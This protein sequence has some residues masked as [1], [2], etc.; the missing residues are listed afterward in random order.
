MSR[1]FPIVQIASIASDESGSIAIGPFGSAMK[2]DLYVSEGVPVIR[3]NNVGAGRKVEGDF[4]YVS[5]ETALRLKRSRLKT[6]D[7]FF[8]HRGAIGTVGIIDDSWPIAPLM[9]SS[10]MRLR[11]NM[12]IA[13]PE[14]VFWFFKSAEGRHEILTYASTVGTPGIGTPLTSLKSM[15]LPLPPLPEQRE[16]AAILG[17]LDDKIELN[18]KTS[19]TL[20]AMARALY[21]SWFV[22]FDPVHARVEGRRPAHMP[23]QTA[24]LFPDSFGEDGLPEGW[25]WAKI[26]KELVIL[27]SKRV[28]LS[29][30]QREAKRGDIP[31]YGATSIMDYVDEALFDEELL[32]VGEDGSVVKPDGKPF[33]QYI[34]GPAWVN[35]HAHVLKGRRFSVGQLKCFFDQVEIA[36]FVNGAV[37]AKLNQ[38][39]L[40]RVPYIEAGSAIHAAFDEIV[41]GWFEKF[42]LLNSQIETL[43]TLRDTLLPRLMSGE[44]RVGAARAEVEAAL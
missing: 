3:G 2:A 1:P 33:T 15:R 6:N 16:I 39:N 35:N 4:V 12:T 19:A 23:S 30:S 22:D 13:D 11:L 28:P 24:A 42:R 8:P 9:S 14:F 40:K 17:A 31:Y 25:A 26:G 36:P 7:I 20:E 10:L 27:D 5:E 38:G 32:L 18:R 44:L 37:Q 21:R 41:Q 29:K 34:W 43:A